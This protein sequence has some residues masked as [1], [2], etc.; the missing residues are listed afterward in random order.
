MTISLNIAITPATIS[1]FFAELVAFHSPQLDRIEAVLNQ[2][3]AKE[4]TIMTDLTELTAEVQR[5]TTVEKSALALIQGFAAQLAAAGTDPVALKAL[6]DSL[7]ANDDELADA[8]VA[9]T[10]VQPVPNPP[11][12]AA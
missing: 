3:L 6:S 4:A 10:P 11:A 8:L 5:N 1:A 7:K 12:D 9:N 2:V